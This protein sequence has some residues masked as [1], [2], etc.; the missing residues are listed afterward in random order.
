MDRIFTAS[1]SCKSKCQRMGHGGTTMNVIAI[2]H[3]IK[4]LLNSSLNSRPA[5][6]RSFYIILSMKWTLEDHLILIQAFSRHVWLSSHT[7][8][9]TC[10][11]RCSPRVILLIPLRL[12]VSEKSGAVEFQHDELSLRSNHHLSR[13]D[14]DNWVWLTS[15][16]LSM[17]AA[18]ASAISYSTNQTSYANGAMMTDSSPT[19]NA[20]VCHVL[21]I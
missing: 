5:T 12:K 9:G 4:V 3:N 15:A 20:S 14:V 17:F 13:T 18:R 11:R 21:Y 1:V 8:L 7:A 10:L 6:T 16:C 2:T 19:S